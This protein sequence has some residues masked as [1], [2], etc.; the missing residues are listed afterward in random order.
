MWKD[1]KNENWMIRR[2]IRK[3]SILQEDREGIGE[4]CND[5]HEHYDQ[6]HRGDH[7]HDQNDVDGAQMMIRTIGMIERHSHDWES[8]KGPRIYLLGIYNL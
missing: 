2:K 1:L 7:H 5:Q 8:G 3:Q 4:G 6:D